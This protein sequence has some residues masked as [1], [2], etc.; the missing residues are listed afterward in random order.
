MVRSIHPGLTQKSIWG[1]R[2]NI[3]LVP[4]H[5][6]GKHKILADALS[7]SNKLVSTEWTLHMDVVQ[8][9]RDLRGSPTID[10]FAMK[11]NNRLPQYMSYAGSGSISSECLG[12]I[13]VRHECSRISSDPSHSGSAEQGD[14][15]QGSPVSD[16]SLLAQP[17]MVSNST[18]VADRPPHTWRLPEWDH[19]LWH[20]LGRVYHNSPSL[21]KLHAWKLSGASSEQD[22]FLRMLSAASPLLRGGE[23]LTPISQSGL[24]TKLGVG[25][26]EFVQSFPLFTSQWIFS[27]TFSQ[28]GNFLSWPLKVI[29]PLQLLP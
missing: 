2:E 21:Y 13:M 27:T 18:R 28:K 3:I 8:A 26:K 5:I 17:S 24:S 4:R 25:E 29:S 1:F 7:R 6:P 23:P 16:H 12:C 19:L 10:L 11:L 22:N 20:P 15:G 14:D 9:V